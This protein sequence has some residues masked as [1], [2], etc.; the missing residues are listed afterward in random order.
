[1]NDT[2]FFSFSGLAFKTPGDEAEESMNIQIA[3]EKLRQF[4]M[5]RSD[6]EAA[7]TALAFLERKFPQLKPLAD[8]MRFALSWDDFDPSDQKRKLA[9][10]AYNDLADRLNGNG[11]HR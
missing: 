8:Q 1:M 11:V 2:P 6:Q 7:A 5:N 10:R 4:A 3:M 9:V